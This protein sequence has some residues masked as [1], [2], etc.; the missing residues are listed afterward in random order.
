MALLGIDLAAQ[1]ADLLSELLLL[2]LPTVQFPL[3]PVV[4]IVQG[5]KL[6]NRLLV[7]LEEN[8]V[9]DF[10]IFGFGESELGNAEV[11]LQARDL[12]L[13]AVHLPHIELHIMPGGRVPVDLP[14]RH[15][16]PQPL[17]PLLPPSPALGTRLAPNRS[18]VCLRVLPV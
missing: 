6:G 5:Q 1:V 13:V 9:F 10:E 11:V 4:F 12:H 2:H 16:P 7:F 18:I 14:L 15:L 3:G 8:V 17:L